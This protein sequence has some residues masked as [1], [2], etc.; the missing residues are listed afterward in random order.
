MCG[1][2]ARARPPLD[3]LVP[4]TTD[5]DPH[6]F[7]VDPTPRWNI[8]PSTRQ[9][10]AYADGNV[11][12]VLWGYRPAWAADKGL[13]PMI[14]ATIEKW[15][16]S[17]WKGQWNRGRVIVPAD[18]WYEWLSVAD[19]KQPY[20]IHRTDTAPL[21]F[22]GLASVG[23]GAAPREGDGFVIVTTAADG[24]L[25][26]V[27]HRRPLVFDAGAARA[28]IEAESADMAREIAQSGNLAADAF[29]CYPVGRAVNSVRNDGPGLVERQ[30]LN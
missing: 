14:N 29:E 20:C 2:Y 9:W 23:P 10:V 28:W 30:A 16:T 19:G 18:A 8:A 27:H 15:S 25:V 13:K 22:G 21:Y 11:A 24:H 7:D 12:S 3:Y 17:A 6:L 26:D 4:L 5:H 1:R